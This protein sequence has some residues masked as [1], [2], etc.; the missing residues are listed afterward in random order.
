MQPLGGVIP[1]PRAFTS[2][3][4]DLA[5]SFDEVD[6]EI[7]A[8]ARSLTQLKDAGFRDDANSG[9]A[10]RRSSQAVI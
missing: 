3:A 7:M 8:R 9:W 5:W 1:K 2:G 6:R 4:R 10:A